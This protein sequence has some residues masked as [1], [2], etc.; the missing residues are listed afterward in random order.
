MEQR[1]SPAPTHQR[2][3]AAAHAWWRAPSP[4]AITAI[5][6]ALFTLL[7]LPFVRLVVLAFSNELGANPVE[8]VTRSTGWWTLFLICITLCVT[9]LR[10]ITAL[11][12]LLKLRRMLG[13]FAFFYVS[14]HF[15]TYLWWD[16]FFDLASIVKDIVKRPFI[17]VGFAAFVLLV[18]MALTSFN[19]AIRWM[20]A[21]RWQRLHYAIYVIVLLGVLHFWWHKAGK[22]DLIEPALFALAAAVL[23]GYRV[24]ARLRA[25]TP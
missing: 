6:W 24:W 21:K 23:L 9:P 16:Q 13:L 18:P 4:R 3:R 2:G 12:W 14:L 8:F 19:A 25:S 15:T 20:G 17:T 1:L 7:L 22:N 5:K 10:K 11:H